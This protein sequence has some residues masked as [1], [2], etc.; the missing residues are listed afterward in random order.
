MT[1]L[2]GSVGR[3]VTLRGTAHHAHAGAVLV[4][5][6]LDLPVYLD[7]VAEWGDRAGTEVGVTGV[8]RLVE[9]T[10]GAPAATGGARHG[11]VGPVYVLTEPSIHS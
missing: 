4:L 9:S 2:A 8:L 7:D 11:V 1:D 3:R 10:A 5:E 6:D